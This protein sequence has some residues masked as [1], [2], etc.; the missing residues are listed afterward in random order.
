MPIEYRICFSDF[1]LPTYGPMPLLVCQYVVGLGYQQTFTPR[2]GTR[3]KRLP[4]RFVRMN[5]DKRA[6]CFFGCLAREVHVSGRTF[7]QLA[8]KAENCCGTVSFV[9]G[10]FEMSVDEISV[11]TPG[12]A[13]FDH[14]GS[15][16]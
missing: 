14:V 6:T 10:R 15:A 5:S 9:L 7:S 12:I 2:F 1:R 11:E 16:S 4:Q 8:R 3:Q 13:P